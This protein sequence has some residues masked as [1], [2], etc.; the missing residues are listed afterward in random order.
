MLQ[1]ITVI[2]L[3]V[4]RNNKSRRLCQRAICGICFFQSLSSLNMCKNSTFRQYCAVDVRI[5]GIYPRPC[6]YQRPFLF[7]NSFYHLQKILHM[8]TL[9]Y[10][11]TITFLF[12]TS[13]EASSSHFLLTA[14]LLFLSLL[15][16]LCAR[17]IYSLSSDRCVGNIS[18]HND[19]ASSIKLI[20][21]L[22][23]FCQFNLKFS[24]LAL[25][26][27][28]RLKIYKKNSLSLAIVYANI[29]VETRT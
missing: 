9:T 5:P 14:F 10:P 3:R 23:Y 28:H 20:Q 16:Y 4:I 18:I 1:N 12:L 8:F 17:E 27:R 19:L 22:V 2:I 21:T 26:S 29:C 7:D 25:F 24:F 6:A 15:L 13:Q 11:T